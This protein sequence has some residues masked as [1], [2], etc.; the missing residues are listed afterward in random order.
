MQESG[1][2]TRH[3]GIGALGTWHWGHGTLGTEA[4]GIVVLWHSHR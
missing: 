4:L 1:L 3:W 2:G